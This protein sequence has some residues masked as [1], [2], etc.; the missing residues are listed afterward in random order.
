MHLRPGL[1]RPSRRLGRMAPRY[2]GSTG[3]PAAG[4]TLISVDKW[5]DQPRSNTRHW[6]VHHRHS[7]WLPGIA[8]GHV[9]RV[10]IGGRQPSG[11]I[12]PRAVQ[13]MQT[14]QTMNTMPRGGHPSR[15]MHDLHPCPMSGDSRI[16][17]LCLGTRVAGILTRV[18][19]N[20]PLASLIIATVRL[21]VDGPGRLGTNQLLVLV[22]VVFQRDT[23]ANLPHT[24]RTSN[25]PSLFATAAGLSFVGAV[26]CAIV[27]D[28]LCRRGHAVDD[29]A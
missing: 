9:H 12:R 11:R 14:M 5:R 17:A 22:L 4:A 28:P 26:L 19:G 23:A 13:T 8:A 27:P 24:P 29:R 25:L 1:V 18:P 7:K 10:H 2:G 20:H 3:V 6:H 15:H 21:N 16:D